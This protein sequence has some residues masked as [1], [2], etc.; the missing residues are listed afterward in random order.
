MVNAFLELV[1]RKYTGP[2]LETLSSSKK[3][4]SP[5]SFSF[6]FL[7]LVLTVFESSLGPFERLLS[8]VF[9]CFL[10]S[11]MSGS[12]STPSPS[13]NMHS[14]STDS[15]H[16]GS[17]TTPSSPSFASVV[18][19]SAI[20]LSHSYFQSHSAM[21]TSPSLAPQQH[22]QKQQKHQHGQTSPSS[23][24][25]YNS[26]KISASLPALSSA[27]S[28]S[29]SNHSPARSSSSTHDSA[30]ASPAFRSF[31]ANQSSNGSNGPDQSSSDSS[32][33]EIYLNS[34]VMHD[35]VSRTYGM[36]LIYAALAPFS[37]FFGFL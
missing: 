15:E 37:F 18:S 32:D 1:L 28:S 29:Q 16:G 20:P 9:F 5:C 14:S 7:S 17:T 24:Y 6:S 23:V 3:R 21:S 31:S 35:S 25:D 22:Q 13:R 2:R 4:R 34:L 11:F 27:A 36:Y 26:M 33:V 8:V 12:H 30:L 10:C 19:S